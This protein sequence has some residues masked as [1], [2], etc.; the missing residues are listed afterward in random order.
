MWWLG[1]GEV[2]VVG[3]LLMGQRLWRCMGVVRVGV[4]CMERVAGGG[5]RMRAMWG[6]GGGVR[7]GG[8][9][10]LREHRWRQVIGGWHHTAG[11]AAITA[12]RQKGRACRLWRL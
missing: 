8:W 4:G 2:E 10:R 12:K 7:H 6:V 9:G 11:R 3:L 1:M 5:D